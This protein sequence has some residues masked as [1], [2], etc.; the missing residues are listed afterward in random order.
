MKRRAVHF[1]GAAAAG[2]GNALV[3]ATTM[4]YLPLGL[5]GPGPAAIL[6]IGLQTAG[7]MIKHR[8]SNL[9]GLPIGPKN[10]YHLCSGFSSLDQ[11]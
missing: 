9:N 4:A 11:D 8:E 3:G 7:G 6:L 1:V 5:D 2:V 10:R